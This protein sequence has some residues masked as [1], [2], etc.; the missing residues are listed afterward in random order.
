MFKIIAFAFAAIGFTSA[1]AL[2]LEMPKGEV[3]LTVSGALDNPNRGADA[4]FDIEMLEALD[5]RTASMETP[6]TKGPVVFS[7]PFLKDVLKAAGAR[8]NQ[9]VIR[10]LND[11]VAWIPASDATDF[12]TILASRMFGKPMVVRDKGPLMLVYPFDQ[13]KALYNEKYFSRSVWQ[14]KEIE[15]VE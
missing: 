6:W 1:A 2:A 9:L 5:G 12:D 14:I 3:I 13:D 8:G 15:V 10:A 11:Y 7:G 4:V